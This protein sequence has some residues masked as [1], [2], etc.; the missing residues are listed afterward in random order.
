MSF[1]LLDSTGARYNLSRAIFAN[2]TVNAPEV[3]DMGTP[4]YS[5]AFVLGK[6]GT[7]FSVSSAIVAA[8]LYNYQDLRS[9]CAWKSNELKPDAGGVQPRLEKKTSEF[10]TLFV[11]CSSHH[12]KD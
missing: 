7:A 1:N 4:Y 8:I 5:T 10:S 9:A 12:H 11:D 3:Q 2:G 6:A